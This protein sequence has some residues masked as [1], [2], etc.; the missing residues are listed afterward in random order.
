[1][2]TPK[3]SIITCTGGRPAAFS[4]LEKYVARQ[5]Y[6]NIEW[7]V[8]DDCEPTVKCTMGQRY[9]RGPETWTPEVNTQR[10]N[11]NVA[12]AKVRG[13]Y[14][15]VLEDDDYYAPT[16]IEDMLSAL[17]YSR[18]VGISNAR[19][20]KVDLPGYAILQNYQHSSLS[21]TAFSKNLLPTIKRCVNSGQFYFDIEIWKTARREQ[22]PFAL[23]ANTS[24]SVGIKGMPG[25]L[26][27]TPAHKENKGF[28]RDYG[29][30]VLE[31]WI[32]EDAK[33]Y[34]PYIKK[35]IVNLEKAA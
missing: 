28:I 10:G 26:G 33:N 27:L 21:Q 12:L 14:I 15:F 29:G 8:I 24:L 3:I 23:I 11:M 30:K 34:L 22:I 20:Y 2:E 4:L 7:I 13:E 1:M 17:K 32:G 35:R 31:T 16:Y 9:Y 19:Y 5:T 25:R 6:Q 18:L